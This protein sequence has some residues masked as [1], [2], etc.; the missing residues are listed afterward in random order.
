[1]YVCN[2]VM[3]VCM[4]VCNYVMYVDIFKYTYP[5]PD[6]IYVPIFPERA[7]LPRLHGAPQLGSI[8]CHWW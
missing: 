2:H 4:Y 6:F 3:Y 8:H 1:M 5:R 7:C